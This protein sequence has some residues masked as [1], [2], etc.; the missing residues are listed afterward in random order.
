MASEADSSWFPTEP[1]SAVSALRQAKLLSPEP[2]P[3]SSQLLRSE[4]TRILQ[5]T[6][7]PWRFCTSNRDYSLCRTY[8]R[9]FPVPAQIGDT[10]LHH[11]A[12][13]RIRQR[14]PLLAYVCARPWCT[15]LLRSS[16]PL[17]GLTGR[18]CVQDEKLIEAF[19]AAV[20][21]VDSA[22][23]K[24]LLIV[25]ARPTTSA[26]ANT[27][28][29]AGVERLEY[30]EA[31]ERVYLSLENIHAVR[32]AHLKLTRALKEQKWHEAEGQSGWLEHLQRIL[33]GVKRI[34]AALPESH[35][36]VHCSD[37]WDRTTQL[38]SLAQ[39][40]LDPFYRTAVGFKALIAKDWLSAGHRFA[41]RN[42]HL[43]RPQSTK[44]ETS[45]E[46]CP[47]FLQFI[48]VV[49]QLCR[50]FPLHFGELSDEVLL[51]VVDAAQAGDAEFFGNCE[52]DRSGG[53]DCKDGDIARDLTVEIPDH[54]PGHGKGRVSESFEVQEKQ[55]DPLLPHSEREK[56][57]LWP[58]YYKRYQ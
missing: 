56:M 54:L 21:A 37:G 26:L 13:F 10:V 44:L 4:W 18:R 25:D 53:A 28:I 35:V 34:L 7:G 41:D 42:G 47:I 17:V 29:G 45:E 31:S 30:Y 9:T 2:Q 5:D 57:I 24:R 11:A 58:A 33:E 55:L 22:G 12:Q 27:V 23:S 43:R 1:L 3:Q 49:V 20:R 46:F 36:L 48:E 19:K 38:V 39:L 50:Q 16:Q 32:E 6:H 51:G 52:A 14:F 40:C 15:A 8:P